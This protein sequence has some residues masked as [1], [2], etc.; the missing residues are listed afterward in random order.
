MQ[1]N[2]L[3]YVK[4]VKSLAQIAASA[5]EA[6]GTFFEDD[7]RSFHGKMALK[8]AARYDRA[9]RESGARKPTIFIVHDDADYA[10]RKWITR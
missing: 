9:I 3:A 6:R 8:I 7:L 5:D 2:D 10:R 1:I 4:A